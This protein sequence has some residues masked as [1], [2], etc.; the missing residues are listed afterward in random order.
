MD[1]PDVLDLT[2][3]VAI[4]LDLTQTVAI[5]AAL[6]FAYVQARHATRSARAASTFQMVN[7]HRDLWFK[8]LDN[9]R[10]ERIFASEANLVNDPISEAERIFVNAL[11]THMYSVVTASK[12]GILD[13]P[14]EWNAELQAFFSLP[15]PLQVWKE[16]RQYY[17]D[18]FVKL[19]EEAASIQ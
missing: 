13:I 15:I 5:V 2:Q 18:S 6:W 17:E 14:R 11:I 1:P 12:Q 7:S 8:A 19:V 4:V 3:T 10:L 16:N 9:P